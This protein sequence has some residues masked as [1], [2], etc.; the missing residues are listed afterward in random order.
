MNPD[1]IH[2]EIRDY[3]NFLIERGLTLKDIA[4]LLDLEVGTRFVKA[5]VKWYRYCALAKENQ[6]LAILKHPDLYSLAGKIAQQKHPWIGHE[7]GKKYS[8]MIG[9][10]RVNK[11]REEGR[12]SE[13]MS[14]IA[15]KL[16][17]INPEHSRKN[18]KKAHETMMNKGTFNSHQKE[19]ALACRIKHPKQLKEMSKTAHSKYPLALLALDSRRKNYPYLYNE[20]YFDSEEE[21]IVCQRFVESGLLE[22]PI[23]NVNVHIRIN[24]KHIDFFIQNKI[25]VEYHPTRTYGRNVETAE[26]YFK[27]RRKILDD[28]GYNNYPLIIIKNMRETNSKIEETKRLLHSPSK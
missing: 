13:H 27:E 22:K 8:A 1:K 7:L 20:C 5:T 23:E 3:V 4:E 28:N 26:D 6:K 21:R 17:Q 19:A 9:R 15:K 25:F 14:I 16:Q 2:N 11:L 24:R 12:L 10:N 18:M